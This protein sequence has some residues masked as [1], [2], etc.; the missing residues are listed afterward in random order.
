MRA[1]TRI[2]INC[3]MLL[4]IPIAGRAPVHSRGLLSRSPR[5]IAVLAGLEVPAG[6]R[7]GSRSRPD[8]FSEETEDRLRPLRCES[9]KII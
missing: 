6:Q 3:R 1:I 9:C 7:W 2:V 4:T 8:H 5:S